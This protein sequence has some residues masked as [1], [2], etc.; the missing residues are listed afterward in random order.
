M[1][2]AFVPLLRL[3]NPYL[4]KKLQHGLF[5]LFPGNILMVL[6]KHL[7]HLLSHGNQGIQGGH[8][9]LEDHGDLFAAY[10]AHPLPGRSYQLFAVKADGGTLLNPGRIRKQM[11]DG[12]GGYALAAAGLPHNAQDFALSHGEAHTPYR[13]DLSVACHKGY[14]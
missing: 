8:G 1:G 11:Q 9:V 3:R 5:C 12:H 2:I 4:C 7:G 6:K 10:L 14:F 13:L